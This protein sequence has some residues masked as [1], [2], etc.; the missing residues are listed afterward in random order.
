MKASLAALAALLLIALCSEVHAAP[1]GSDTTPCC[2]FHAKRQIPL[3]HV[4]EYYYTSSRCPK[5]AVVFI[6]RK[7]R[8]ICTDPESDWVKDYVNNLE[9]N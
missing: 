1:V 3:R 7:N 2:F 5:P 6:T 4:R 8:Q 9:M